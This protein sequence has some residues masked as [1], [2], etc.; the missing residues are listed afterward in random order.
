MNNAEL[1]EKYYELHNITKSMKE[2]QKQ[3]RLIDEQE[4]EIRSVMDGLDILAATKEGTDL[5]VPISPG[6]FVSAVLKSNSKLLVNVGANV[7]VEKDI[8]DT[9]ALLDQRI[10]E[11]RE[12]KVEVLTNLRELSAHA[13]ELEQHVQKLM[14]ASGE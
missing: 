7:T 4:A 12:A 10:L 3:V 1:Q 14:E 8:A 5:Q 9:K 11:M 6:I 13:E 2:M